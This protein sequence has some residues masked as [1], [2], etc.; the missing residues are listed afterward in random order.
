MRKEKQIKV[1]WDKKNKLRLN[2][3]RKT[4]QGFYF[5]ILNLVWFLFVC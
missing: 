4:M 3:I 5:F 2:E 1:K